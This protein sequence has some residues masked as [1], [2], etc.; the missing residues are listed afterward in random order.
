MQTAHELFLHELSD[1]L[2]AEQKL[3]E[4]LGKQ[5][6][7]SSRP[8]LQKAFEHHRQQTEKQ[9]K[10]LEQVFESLEEDPEHAECKG[11]AGIIGE[12]DEFMNEQS[13]SGDLVDIFNAGAACKVEHYEIAAYTSLIQLAQQMG[14]KKA[15][16]LLNQNLKEE[17]QTLKKM[18]GFIKKLKP[19]HMHPEEVEEIEEVR[20]EQI[21]ERQRRVA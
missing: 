5:T 10:R 18:E 11:M 7:E 21:S 13:P 3:V 16:K 17:Q 12:H 9:V 20:G 2:D 8:D 6:V 14:H 15:V 1:M 4:A 19:Q